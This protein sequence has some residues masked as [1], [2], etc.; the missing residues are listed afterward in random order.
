MVREVLSVSKAAWDFSDQLNST[1]VEVVVW[2]GE[3]IPA[4]LRM[5]RRYY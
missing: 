5:K 2:I 1:L 4:K 3:D